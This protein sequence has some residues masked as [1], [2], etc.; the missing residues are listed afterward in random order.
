ME[1]NTIKNIRHY[2]PALNYFLILLS[3]K[4]K[5]QIKELKFKCPSLKEIAVIH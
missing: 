1:A 2:S 5:K 3:N 4:V